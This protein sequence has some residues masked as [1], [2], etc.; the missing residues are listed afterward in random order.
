MTW[1]FK[2]QCSLPSHMHHTE[3]PVL[4]Y[5]YTCFSSQLA[6]EMT[7]DADVNCES[8]RLCVLY[9]NAG[10]TFGA[11]FSGDEP[12]LPPEKGEVTKV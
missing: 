3:T 12:L 1:C 6:G 7:D 11:C 8:T 4:I 2:V 9:Q 5:L 10:L